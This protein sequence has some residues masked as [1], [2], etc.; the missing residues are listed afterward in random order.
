MQMYNFRLFRLP[1]P[2]TPHLSLSLLSPTFPGPSFC[3]WTDFPLLGRREVIIRK[4]RAG[5]P[6]I[7][8]VLSGFDIALD[9]AGVKKST[10]QRRK[11]APGGHRGG[12]RSLAIH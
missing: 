11:T 9:S 1:A 10:D 6:S 12:E 5:R 2:P 4:R 3:H 8:Q 7:P